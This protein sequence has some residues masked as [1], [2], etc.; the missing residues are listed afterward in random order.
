MTIPLWRKD[1]GGGR[2][3]PRYAIYDMNGKR[4]MFVNH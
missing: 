3:C 4:F 1:S 2:E